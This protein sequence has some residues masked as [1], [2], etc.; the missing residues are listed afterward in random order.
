MIY[1]Q[2]LEDFWGDVMSE[3]TKAAQKE[4]PKVKLPESI[5]TIQVRLPKALSPLKAPGQAA[6]SAAKKTA[7]S[8]F[9]EAHAKRAASYAKEAAQREKDRFELLYFDPIKETFFGKG[10][11]TDTLILVVGGAALVYLLMRKR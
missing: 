3:A 6:F 2:P 4:I 10:N 1:N 7:I 8:K 11:T 9:N 5:R